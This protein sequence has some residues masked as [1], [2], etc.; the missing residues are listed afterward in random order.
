MSTAISGECG[1]G[2]WDATLTILKKQD[3]NL[4]T[5]CDMSDALEEKHSI[6][7]D[8]VN[9]S[10]KE[11]DFRI[12]IRVDDDVEECFSTKFHISAYGR[13]G[14]RL[15]LPISIPEDTYNGLTLCSQKNMSCVPSVDKFDWASKPEEVD[16]T[17]TPKFDIQLS[18]DKPHSRFC[19]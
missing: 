1:T 18:V 10:I 8:T 9:S 3:C 11:T 19:Q 16:G 5:A 6:D 15:D 4:D 13:D 12:A 17:V 2:D 14:A 7:N